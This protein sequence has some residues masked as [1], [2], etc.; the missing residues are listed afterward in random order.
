MSQR[1]RTAAEKA[2]VLIEASQKIWDSKG[3][4]KGGCIS[5]HHQ[6]LP[7][8][9]FRV[10]REHGLRVNEEVALDHSAKVFSF[11]ET[12]D[13]AVQYTH[14]IEP[15]M[16]DALRLIAEDAT[17]ARPTLTRAVYARLIASRQSASGAWDCDSLHQRP[18][19]SYSPF[20]HTALAI[21]ALQLYGHSS[22]KADTEARVF[23]ARNWLVGA[24]PRETEERTFQLL[25][26]WWAGADPA[27][28]QKLGAQLIL[29]QRADGGW[30][31][32]DGRASD[33]YST[34]EAL[35]ALHDAARVQASN[36]A[37]RRGLEFLLKTQLPDGSWHV[38][39]RLEP[40]LPLSPPYV[41]TG[42]PYGHDQFISIE[43]A[44][45]AIMALSYA[46]GPTRAMVGPVLRDGEQSNL[47]PW[48][49]TIL[50]GTGADLTR[51]LDG[52]FDPNSST[53]SGH[54]TALMM[55]A[56]DSKKMKM[57]LDRGADVNGRATTK[58]SAL[59]VAAQYSDSS[60]AIR[61]LLDR[62]AQVHLAPRSGRAAI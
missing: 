12:L 9:A 19:S 49:E 20:T 21:R 25:G 6:L 16:F 27:V 3:L 40:S 11:Y 53:K 56:P 8:I 31:S 2:I 32:L 7:A 43:S 37:W 44:S 4:A 45:W 13:R 51:L 58:Y 35:V 29:T 33:A 22:L 47:E 46:L 41:D 38:G 1:L 26:L 55:A 50:F 34:A 30:N 52:G 14:V 39:S 57:L 10:A 59:M 48:A 5:C 18:P 17:G 28:M 61:M 42:Y 62:G 60:A 36:P 23:R 54:T 24:N 15:S